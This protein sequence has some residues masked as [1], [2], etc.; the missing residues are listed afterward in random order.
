MGDFDL[1]TPQLSPS[2]DFASPATNA[3]PSG[4]LAN[5]GT[6]SVL[7]MPAANFASILGML[8]SA[9]SPKGSTGDRLG[10]VATALGTTHIRGE[11][12]QQQMKNHNQLLSEFLKQ[13]GDFN[14]LTPEQAKVL[15]GGSSL[16]LGENSSPLSS[17]LSLGDFQM[18]PAKL[19]ELNT[20][21]KE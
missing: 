11:L 21:P 8:G 19:G 14:K 5:F 13:G 6:G 12:A 15:M 20:T 9:I 10:Q 16:S 4:L 2:V 7:G 18:T 17:G 1:G 3:R